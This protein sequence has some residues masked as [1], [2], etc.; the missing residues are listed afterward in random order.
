M[1]HSV[2]EDTE[3]SWKA[4][5][6]CYRRR[7]A[8]TEWLLASGGRMSPEKALLNHDAERKHVGLARERAYCP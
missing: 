3:I 6:H 4:L 2:Y 7:P 1:N 8:R 5:L